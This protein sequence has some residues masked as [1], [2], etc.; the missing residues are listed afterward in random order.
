MIN[1]LEFLG[2]YKASES[3]TS[4]IASSGTADGNITPPAGQVYQA[5]NAFLTI[6]APPGA[7]S[8][9][10]TFNIFNGTSSTVG[11]GD[12]WI[13]LIS[14]FG[15]NILIRGNLLTGSSSELPANDIDQYNIWQ[16]CWYSNKYPLY[17]SYSNNTD[18]DQT[19][20][21]SLSLLFKVYNSVI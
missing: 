14:L 19:N 6:V 10:H 8:G 2:L 4:T 17:W 3:Y 13:R 1:Q 11:S 9:S 7:S 21:L 5:V 15:D 20:N 16:K 12:S 18:I